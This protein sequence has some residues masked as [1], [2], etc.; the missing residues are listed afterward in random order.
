MI[1]RGYAALFNVPQRVRGEVEILQADCFDNMIARK[2]RCAL[3]GDTH[4]RKANQLACNRDGSLR[5]FADEYGLAFQ[6]R[7]DQDDPTLEELLPLIESGEA[8]CSVHFV[9][10]VQDVFE[11][12]YIISLGIIDHIAITASPAYQDTC[13]WRAD[14]DVPAH[15]KAVAD[16]WE[17]SWSALT[18]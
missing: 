16:G 8:G 3:Q 1:L 4:D 2:L 12:A 17:E 14:S 11:G 15:L 5:L 10:C 9:Q 13:C 6:A 18:Q 7:V